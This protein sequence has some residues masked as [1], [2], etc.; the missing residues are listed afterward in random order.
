MTTIHPTLKPLIQELK[1]T[2]IKYYLASTEFSRLCN[3]K[4]FE[5]TWDKFYKEAERSRNFVSVGFNHEAFDSENA[6][7]S[8]LDAAFSEENRKS[9]DWI[10]CFILIG[11][12]KWSK[13][14]V[15]LSN[16]FRDLKHLNVNE[17]FR[18]ELKQVYDSQKIIYQKK[19]KSQIEKRP[20]IQEAKQLSFEEKKKNWIKYIAK[21]EVQKVVDELIDFGIE[22]DLDQFLIL[23][24]RW[25]SMQ[26]DFHKGIM[27]RDDFELENNK[28]VHSL[29]NFVKNIEHD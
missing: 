14:E 29:L 27:K 11:F 22:N 28:I 26:S 20:I 21:A 9:F 13:E 8:L 2:P 7:I 10:V 15:E 3:E 16:I 6:L 17:N 23:S 5:R 25:H 24:N 1:V 18:V 19:G 12:V 4:N